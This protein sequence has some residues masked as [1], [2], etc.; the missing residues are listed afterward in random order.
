MSPPAAVLLICALVMTGCALHTPEGAAKRFVRALDNRI[1]PSPGP[2]AFERARVSLRLTERQPKQQAG[3]IFR[4][5]AVWA[6]GKHGIAL[7]SSEVLRDA[8]GRFD[9]R[10]SWSPPRPL[11]PGL[12]ERL[13]GQPYG[14]SG[15]WDN[16]WIVGGGI[17]EYRVT[18]TETP[19]LLF[20][21][22][23]YVGDPLD[24]LEAVDLPRLPSLR[25]VRLYLQQH[26]VGNATQRDEGAGIRSETVHTTEGVSLSAYSEPGPGG[27]PYLVGLAVS[28]PRKGS[29]RPSPESFVSILRHLGF[30]E[31]DRVVPPIFAAG[32]PAAE[33]KE[34]FAVSGNFALALDPSGNVL[35]L[36]VWR[37]I[38]SPREWCRHFRP[39]L[40]R[41]SVAGA[42][43]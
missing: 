3:G 17:L 39:D 25:A 2:L 9:L 43:R 11:H 24:L 6:G 35:T 40:E 27:D 14:R 34:S 13:L 15:T 31:P 20:S 5:S 29:L 18:Q 42:S 7:G 41:C 12:V 36:T 23:A 4:K 28:I 26:G 33:P 1:A 19:Y 10:L 37:R 32:P 8:P 16:G 30:P 22:P 21:S 38:E